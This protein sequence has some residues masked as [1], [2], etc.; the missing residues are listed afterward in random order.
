MMKKSLIGLIFLFSLNSYS[1]YWTEIRE[2]EVGPMLNFHYTSLYT[3][4]GLL[5]DK[6][7]GGFSNA[8]YE[9]NFAL[10]IYAIY[11]PKSNIGFGAELFYDRTSAKELERDEHYN[12]L[13]FLA[14]INFDPFRRIKNIYF[15]AGIGASFIQEAPDFGNLVLEEDIRVITVPVKLSASY[16]FRNQATVEI[17]GYVEATEVV[18]EQ[19][20]RNA[21]FLGLKIPMNRVFGGYR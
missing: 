19:V 1:Q 3:A 2:Y 5:N 6:E 13:T 12:S 21:I 14:Y 10:G 8:G 20:R 15:G 4:N 9:P 7:E 16:R 17:G 18:I 11:Y